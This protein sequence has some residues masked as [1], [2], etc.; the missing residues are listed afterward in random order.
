MAR[1]IDWIDERTEIREL[2]REEVTE[3]RAPR[4]RGWTGYLGCFG[5]VSLVFYLMMVM[6]GLFLL[7]YYIPSPQEAFASIEHIE[8]QVKF[9]WLFRRIHAV[10]ANFMIFLVILHMMKVL[11]TGA[12]K[13]PRELHWISGFTLLMMTL[14]LGI[15]GYLLPWTQLSFWAVT[16]LTSSLAVIP[17][18][19]DD[20]VLL[21]RGGPLVTGATL[22]RFFALHLA[23][24]AVM[25]LFL[26]FHFWMIRKT[27]A[28]AP[29]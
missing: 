6:S 11:V 8:N 29:L 26:A 17:L 20:L 16:V 19:G 22:G 14:I 9:G 4:L 7:I 13:P 28:Q 23:T 18:V 10:G 12:Y 25:V 21:V 1:M 24:A 5:G 27:G 3:K 2:I 15:S